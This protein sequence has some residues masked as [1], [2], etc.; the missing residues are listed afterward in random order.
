MR[1]LNFVMSERIQTS[2]VALMIAQTH[3][4]I[5]DVQVIDI[6]RDAHKLG[7]DKKS[8]TF[9]FLIQD[10][11]KTLTDIEMLHIQEQIIARVGEGGHIQLRS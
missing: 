3:P 8:V 6:F 11:E 2:Y 5:S 10:S 7:A 4:S 9:S 1:D